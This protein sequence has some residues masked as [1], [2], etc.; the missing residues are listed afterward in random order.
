[1]Q[2]C[3]LGAHGCDAEIL[4]G[5]STTD[6]VGGGESRGIDE[7]HV[8]VSLDAGPGSLELSA[9]VRIDL[10]LVDGAADSSSLEAKLEP[11]DP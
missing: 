11:A 3:S 2:A 1:M 9:A 7:L 5:K 8:L 10:D 4:A 6:E